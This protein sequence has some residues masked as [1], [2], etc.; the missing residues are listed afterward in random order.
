MKYK[1]TLLV[2]TALTICF[3]INIGEAQISGDIYKISAG[4]VSGGGGGSLSD[5]F[6]L[7]GVVP[8]VGG[9]YISSEGYSIIS[10]SAG[11]VYGGMTTLSTNYGGDAIATIPKADRVLK[12][13]YSGSIGTAAG[14]FYYRQGGVSTFQSAAMTAGTGDTLTYALS[15]ALLTVRGLEYYFEV[16]RD[17]YLSR[18]GGPSSP[19]VFRV[20]LTNEQAQIP[21]ATPTEQYRIIGIPLTIT[22]SNSVASVFE[23][24]LGV[25]NTS[26]WRIGRYSG[27][28]VHEFDDAGPVTPGKGFWLITAEPQTFGAAGNSVRPTAGRN[29]NSIDYFEVPL[30]QGWNQLA[31]PFGFR[32]AWDDIIFDVGGD[33]ETEHL[34]ATLED[35]AYFYNG[36]G[37]ESYEAIPPWSGVFVRINLDNVTALMPFS[38]TSIAPKLAPLKDEPIYSSYSWS[39]ELRMESGKFIDA[40]NFAGVRVDAL[41]G[42]D[43]YDFSEPPPAPSAPNMG[44]RIP[45]DDDRLRRIDYRPPLAQGASW[46]LEM[47][48][49]PGRKISVIGLN[50]IPSGMEAWLFI[51]NGQKFDLFRNPEINLP[52][53]VSKAKLIIG[54]NSF[55]RNEMASI[56]PTDFALEQNYPNPF[57]PLTTI[58]FSL[59]KSGFTTLEIYNVLGQKVKTLVE[60]ELPAGFHTVVWNSED[61]NG[62]ETASG[63]YFYRLFSGDQSAYRKMMLVK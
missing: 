61:N 62:K 35:V 4:G 36:T 16:R 43:F 32:I 12:V 5:L 19:L 3:L 57:N 44:F 10:G 40:D 21:A 37:Y 18:I 30:M 20:G 15:A 14:I 47:A 26:Q 46:E 53:Q 56:I 23:D 31:N 45:N 50:Q 7:T 33:I 55:A 25:Y 48:K 27:G 29:Y 28:S 51:D 60:K 22:G 13:A 41:E 63:V 59:P 52:D 34:P 1:K 9:D 24:D 11:I 2:M 58:K 17:I 39:I 6:V 54:S 38:E 49:A 42:P 8:L